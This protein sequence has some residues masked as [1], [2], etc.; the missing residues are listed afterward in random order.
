MKCIHA[1]HLSGQLKLFHIDPVNMVYSK[2]VG[3]KDRSPNYVLHPIISDIS[4]VV[5]TRFK[6][7]K[8]VNYTSLMIGTQSRLPCRAVQ[9]GEAVLLRNPVSPM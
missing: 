3:K 8:V 9:L 5:T 7:F 6:T 4:Q 2:K 1:L